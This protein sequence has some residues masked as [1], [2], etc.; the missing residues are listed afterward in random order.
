MQRFVI[1]ALHLLLSGKV[2]AEREKPSAAPPAAFCEG[3]NHNTTV[4]IV[5]I[6]LF[7]TF[8]VYKEHIKEAKLDS[9]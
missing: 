7:P 2:R 5:A 6:S 1:R 9:V 8:S 4:S 3:R